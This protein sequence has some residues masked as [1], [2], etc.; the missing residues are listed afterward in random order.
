MGLGTS[1][2]PRPLGAMKKQTMDYKITIHIST[3][4]IVAIKYVAKYPCL[5]Q[6]P[7][8][9]HIVACVYT[10]PGSEAFQGQPPTTRVAFLVWESTEETNGAFVL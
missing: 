8:F 5:Q 6:A 10:P 4:Q 9:I 7:T 1:G 2:E 3:D